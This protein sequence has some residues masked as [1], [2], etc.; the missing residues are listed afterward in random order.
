MAG[1][2]I[3]RLEEIYLEVKSERHHVAAKGE[4]HQ[5]RTLPGKS[6]H[7]GDTQINRNGLI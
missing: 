7:Y 3:A 1:Q 4:G 5:N 2:N 6:Q